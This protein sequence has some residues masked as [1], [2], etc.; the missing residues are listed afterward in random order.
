MLNLV[1]RHTEIVGEIL[2]SQYA[3]PITVA[4]GIAETMLAFW[5]IIG[6]WRKPTSVLQIFLVLCMNIIEFFMVPDLLLWGRTNLIF[7]WMFAAL[8]YIHGFKMQAVAKA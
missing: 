4:I 8:I 1:P 6:K 3:R 2:G 7:A 5:I